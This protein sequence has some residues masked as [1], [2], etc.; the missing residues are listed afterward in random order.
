MRQRFGEIQVLAPGDANHR[1]ACDHAFLQ[2]C[3]GIT[4]LI[5]EQGMKPAET[6]AFD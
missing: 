1:V 2:S 5:V 3:H 6:R 4:G